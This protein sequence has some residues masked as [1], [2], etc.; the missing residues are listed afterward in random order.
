MT[1]SISEDFGFSAV[2]VVPEIPATEQTPVVGS[3]DVDKILAQLEK[4]D[5]IMEKLERLERL[6]NTAHQ[7]AQIATT[8]TTLAEANARTMA[9]RDILLPLLTNL[10]KTSDKDYIYWPNR[11]PVIQKYLDKVNELTRL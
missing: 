8:D 10:L 1:N 6:E 4:L 3:E 5:A 9:L 2:D 11:G 7:I